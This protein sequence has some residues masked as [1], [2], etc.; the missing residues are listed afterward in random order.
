MLS[1]VPAR[2]QE[3]DTLGAD[4]TA[5]PPYGGPVRAAWAALA[6]GCLTVAA[7]LIADEA[8][9]AYTATLRVLS[10]AVWIGCGALLVLRAR[11]SGLVLLTGTMLLAQGLAPAVDTATAGSPSA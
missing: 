9:P 11:P 7:G 5:V 6:A 3:S 1:P 8:I 2:T 10:A 4:R